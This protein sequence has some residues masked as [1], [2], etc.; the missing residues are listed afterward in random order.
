MSY[1]RENFLL[2]TEIAERLYASY[3][4]DMPIFDYHCHLS[5]KQILNNEPFHDVYDIW[6][7][8]DHYKWR[9]MR[10][11]GINESLITGNGTHKEKFIAYCTALGTAFGNPLYHWSQ[12]ELKFFFDCEIEINAQNAERIW[13]DCNR[14]MEEHEITPQS[15]IEK[16]GVKN[17]FTTNEVFDDLS[18]FQKIERKGYNFH[19]APAFRTDKMLNIEAEEYLYYVQLL[20]GVSDFKSFEERLETR[21]NEFIEVGCKAS[22]LSLITVYPVASRE[23]AAT[24]F[25]KRLRQEMLDESEIADFKG[26]LTYYF[27]K[28]YA[29]HRLVC[30]LHVG[31]MRNNNTAMMRS[32]GADTG[33]DCIAEGDMIENMSRLF[34]RLNGEQS[35][36]KTI[37]FNL[38]PRMNAAITTLLGCFQTD[39]AKGKMQY[40]AAWWFLDHKAGIEQQLCDL[41]ATGHIATFIG[42][43]TDS[44]SFLS[45]PRHQY[46]RRILCNYFGNLMSRGEMTQDERLVGAVIQD[47]CYYNAEKYFNV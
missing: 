41:A 14:Y 13:N 17:I 27:M 35:L 37:V 38:N 12:L 30:E 33:Y 31:V 29:K 8:G 32:L 34:D 3:A 25:E 7:S 40:G 45:Y 42:M 39:E 6:L 18:T 5:E 19:V 44:R 10:S 9:M 15:L 21:L 22:D 20:G 2:E 24:V 4:K 28:L 26:Y 46:F 43:L 16:S 11:Y 23:R 1:I 47:I 36:P